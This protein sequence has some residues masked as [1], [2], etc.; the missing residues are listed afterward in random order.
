MRETRLD[1]CGPRR[2]PWLPV[3]WLGWAACCFAA[4]WSA[5]ALDWQTGAGFRCA[6]LA[7]PKSGKDGFT[8]LLEEQTGIAFSNHLSDAAVAQNQIRLVGSGV[9]LG[10]VD[11][12]GWC[13]V[14]LCRLEGPNVLYR[15]L[16]NWKFL[17]VTEGAGVGCRGQYST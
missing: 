2:R 13:D 9:A 10:D 12:D 8:R 6:P 14:Y 3:W 15:N 7:V 4:V 16:G 1:T 11:G 5:K 17:D